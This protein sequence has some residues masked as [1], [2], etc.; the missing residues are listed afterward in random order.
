MHH[1]LGSAQTKGK[2]MQS[3]GVELRV[4][5]VMVEIIEL[6]ER[7]DREAAADLRAADLKVDVEVVKT[8]KTGAPQR[9]GTLKR[10]WKK[11]VGSM[12]G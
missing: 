8:E 4:N 5:D 3:P 9:K 2:E 1:G 12:R 10:V 6:K 11:V 7:R